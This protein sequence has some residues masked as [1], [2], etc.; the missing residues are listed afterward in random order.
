VVHGG[1]PPRP[2]KKASVAFNDHAPLNEL[3]PRAAT[4]ALV[5]IC[6]CTHRAFQQKLRE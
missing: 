3:L 4:V 5:D 2:A 6:P 1:P